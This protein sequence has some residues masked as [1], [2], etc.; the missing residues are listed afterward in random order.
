MQKLEDGLVPLTNMSLNVPS[1]ILFPTERECDKSEVASES[2][3]LSIGE[4]ECS[5]VGSMQLDAERANK[6]LRLQI[7]K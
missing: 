2:T 5:A 3:L 6:Q 7:R 4:W 1:V